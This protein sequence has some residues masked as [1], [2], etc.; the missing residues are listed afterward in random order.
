MKNILIALVIGSVLFTACSKTDNS[1]SSVNTVSIT[2]N[3]YNYIMAST[4]PASTANTVDLTMIKTSSSTALLINAVNPTTGRQFELHLKAY[5]SYTG[6]GLFT[7]SGISSQNQFIEYFAGGHT[8][9]VDSSAI[10]V[11]SASTAF[12]SGTFTLWLTNTLGNKVMTGYFTA[13]NPTFQ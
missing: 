8:Y 7:T 4:N 1:G 2:D 11:S 9:N 13:N 10:Y 6:L 3:G 12:V 5:G